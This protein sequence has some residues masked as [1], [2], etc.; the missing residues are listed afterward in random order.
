MEKYVVD[1]HAL[2]WYLVGSPRLG[3]RARAALDAVVSGEASVIIPAIVVA[4]LVMFAEKYRTIEPDK[5][6]SMLQLES[7]FQF[8]PLMPETAAN[9]QNLTFLP[10]MHDR[11][12]VSEALYQECALISADEKI[13]NSK[14]VEILW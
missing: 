4:E 2:I 12:I 3:T 13:T 6:V 9:I 11:L 14:L 7:G 5:I 8:V 1:T 10:D